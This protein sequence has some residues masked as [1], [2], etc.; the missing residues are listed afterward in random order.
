MPKMENTSHRRDELIK[1]HGALVKLDNVADFMRYL[2]QREAHQRNCSPAAH[3]SQE[4]ASAIVGLV[5]RWPHMWNDLH[6]DDRLDA[7]KRLYQGTQDPEWDTVSREMWFMVVDAVD[8]STQVH[9]VIEQYATARQ[10]METVLFPAYEGDMDELAKD[11]KESL[12]AKSVEALGIA[13][14]RMSST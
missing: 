10:V 4:I 8:W 12:S 1:L 14:L 11:I 2:H 9:N 5:I 3:V 6:T 7:I 13:L